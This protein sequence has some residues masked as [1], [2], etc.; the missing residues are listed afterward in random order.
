MILCWSSLLRQFLFCFMFC[1]YPQ[2]WKG[3][4]KDASALD[5]H[6]ERNIV[7]FRGSNVGGILMRCHPPVCHGTLFRG[8][9]QSDVYPFFGLPKQFLFCF[10][11]EKSGQLRYIG[12]HLVRE[13]WSWLDGSPWNFTFWN[14]N[15]AMNEKSK[16]CIEIEP[17]YDV[18]GWSNVHCNL[19]RYF[20][21]AYKHGN[22][23][24][25]K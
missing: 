24:Y 8:K 3:S 7:W 14:K 12:G 21:C 10:T 18:E 23:H 20:V 4:P 16:R 25:C 6:I 5:A 11:S 9:I 22:I 1:A 19:T 13:K 2:F 17:T 15:P